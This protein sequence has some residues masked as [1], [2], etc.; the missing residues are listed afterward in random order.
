MKPVTVSQIAEDTPS[1]RS[2]YLSGNAYFFSLW[3]TLGLQ[4]AWVDAFYTWFEGVE[5]P[6]PT[7]SQSQSTSPKSYS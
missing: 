3:C 2:R 6:W 1:V 5:G 7:P 4:G